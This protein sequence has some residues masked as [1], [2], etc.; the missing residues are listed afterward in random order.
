[1]TDLEEENDLKKSH[2]LLPEREP[3]NNRYLFMAENKAVFSIQK[4]A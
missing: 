3:I 4:M 1:M 2:D